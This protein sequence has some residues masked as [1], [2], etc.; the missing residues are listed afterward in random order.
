LKYRQ[1]QVSSH[2][3]KNENCLG[4]KPDNDKERKEPIMN[5]NC[6]RLVGDMRTVITDAEG[7]I[8][9]TAGDVTEKAR[10]ARALLRER[11][12]G[13]KASFRALEEKARTGAKVADRAI[14]D[15]PYQ[16]AAIALLAGLVTGFLVGRK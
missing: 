2:E 9:S 14:H 4:T 3:T 7:L 10:E 5:A 15:H 13:A 11:L 16:T 1:A 12:Q 6:E 8:Q